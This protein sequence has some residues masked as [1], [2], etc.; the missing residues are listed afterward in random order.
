LRMQVKKVNLI[1]ILTSPPTQ[2]KSQQ[3]LQHNTSE[4]LKFIYF[5]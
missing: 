1:T 3:S 5:D 4:R 2:T